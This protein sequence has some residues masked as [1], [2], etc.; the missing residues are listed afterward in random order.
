[1]SLDLHCIGS[2]KEKPFRI[3]IIPKLEPKIYN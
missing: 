3:N 2:F 1:M